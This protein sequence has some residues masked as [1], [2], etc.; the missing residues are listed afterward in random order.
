MAISL[1]ITSGDAISKKTLRTCLAV[2]VVAFV[3]AYS[4]LSLIHI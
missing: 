4:L 1:A 2:T 3:L